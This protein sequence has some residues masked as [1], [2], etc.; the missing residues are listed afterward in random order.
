MVIPKLYIGL[1]LNYAGL[2]LGYKGD[3]RSYLGVGGNR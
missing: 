2:Y 1:Y 3:I